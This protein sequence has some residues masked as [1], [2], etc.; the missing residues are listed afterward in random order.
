MRRT[1]D[2]RFVTGAG[3]YTADI[4]LP[5]QLYLY[6]LRSPVAH[7]K[8]KSID[9]TTAASM[10][11]VAGIATAEDLA[12]AGI[13]S[14]PTVW[15]VTDK[16][17][18]PMREPVRPILAA[19]KVAYVGEPVAGVFAASRAAARD[20]AEHI[21]LDLEELPVLTDS[22]QALTENAPRIWDDIPSNCAFASELGDAAR[23]DAAFLE[24]AHLVRTDIVQNRLVSNPM[25][26]RVYA[27][28]S[29]YEPALDAYML[30]VSNQNPLLI[31]YVWW[32]FTL[33]KP[34]S[35]LRV[36]APEILR[37]LPR[38]WRASSMLR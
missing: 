21:T 7:A 29:A 3:R 31:R 24:A 32:R 38:G 27:L 12:R 5:G 18:A 26:P 11:D 25:E 33:Y 36:M 34:E 17:G 2:R 30:E 35:K 13:G 6:V 8:L 22:V 28:V 23:V 9:I 16:S 4:D 15:T 19:D 37:R 1:E 14:M 20:A 10:P